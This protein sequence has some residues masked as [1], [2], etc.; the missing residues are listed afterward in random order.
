MPI[1]R[2]CALLFGQLVIGVV[3]SLPLMAS[4][5]AKISDICHQAAQLAGKQRGVP[6][7][8]LQAITLT[9][10][11]RRLEGSFRPWPWTVNMEGKGF[12]F[13]TRAEALKFVME[14]YEKGARS[15]DVG[16]FH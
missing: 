5:V 9:E 6:M 12:W 11:G 13:D 10:T 7:A 16:C 1:V 2:L 3:L 4:P 14:R 15:F 8:V